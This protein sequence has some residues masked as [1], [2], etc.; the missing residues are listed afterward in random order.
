VARV[1][2]VEDDA[3]I[4]WIVAEDLAERGYEV[5]TARDGAEALRRL[6]HARP[7]VIVLDLM[8][9]GLNGWDF[10]D[11]YQDT[12]AGT[13]IPIV[14]VSASGSGSKSLGARGVRQFLPKPFDLEELASSVADS[15]PAAAG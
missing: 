10:I 2:V 9:P 7:D 13:E 4:A 6:G 11:R 5:T 15:V 8:M 1:L 3:W 12:T 14:V